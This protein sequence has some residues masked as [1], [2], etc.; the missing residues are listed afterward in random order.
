MIPPVDDV[1]T[2]PLAITTSGDPNVTVVPASTMNLAAPPRYSRRLACTDVDMPSGIFT[3]DPPPN[4]TS[5]N[6]KTRPSTVAYGPTEI[7]D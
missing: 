2:E 1:P 4:D 5:D 7:D 3:N 6:D